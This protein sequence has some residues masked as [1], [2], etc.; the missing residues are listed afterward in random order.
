MSPSTPFMSAEDART[1]GGPLLRLHRAALG[2]DP[3][4]AG[5]AALVAAR[6]KGADLL[7]LA[8]VLAGTAEFAAIHGPGG[9]ETPASSA[10]A[11]QVARQAFGSAD[12]PAAAA[13]GASM[14]GLGRAEA[15][16]GIAEAAPVR[17]RSPLLPGLFPDVPP[18][19]PV[20]YAFWIAAHDTMP[21]DAASRI[22]PLSGPRVSLA[23]R[24]GD[25]EAEAVLRS[26]ASL[27]SQVHQDW[28]LRIACQL[29]SPWPR[30][31]IAAA[32]EADPRIVPIDLP[33]TT[34]AIAALN[35]ALAG[36]TGGIVGLLE[37]GDTLPPTALHEALLAFEPGVMLVFTDEDQADSAGHRTAPRF[38]PDYGPD[39]MQAANVIGQLALYRAELMRPLV[40]LDPDAAP[41]AAYDFACRAACLAGPARIR[42][43]PAVLCHRAAP[44]P[45]DPPAAPPPAPPDPPP[46]VT[47]IL[48]TRDR[49][50]L[51]AASAWGVL[52]GTAYPAL[53][54][55]VVD[56][57]SA[58]PAALAL[59]AEIDADP[60]A[61]VLP[62]PGAFNFPAMNNA[63]AHRARG[64]VLLLL[65]NDV[66]L[67]DPGWLGAMVAHAVRPD[68]GAVGARLLYRDGSL[69]H[70]GMA[71]G[72]AGRATHLLRGAPRDAPGYLGQLAATRDLSAVTAACLAMRADV[73]AQV[74]G[75]DER[76]PVAWNDVDLC[77]R[78]RAAG[79]RVIWTPHAVLLH[80]E[81]ETRGE[82]A[83]DPARQARFLADQALYRETW[84]PAADVDP[85][86]NPNL[87][88][89]DHQLML[90]PPRRPRPWHASAGQVASPRQI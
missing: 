26:A 43:V 71:L 70:G 20:A 57:G 80:L 29:R 34:P 8:R 56:N 9:A 50:D 16:A 53:E 61:E 48:P 66:E 25:S 83:A 85:F 32:A 2:R 73:W 4:A 7:D 65:N 19:Q 64:Q 10:F 89:G 40:G 1:V 63:A 13:L 30:R 72:P 14:E 5:L 59:L 17:A 77:Q 39:A 21:P 46:L 28:E 87:F 55:I 49:A 11:A 3:D 23:M 78:V 22:A 67:V 38:K 33:P 68:V 58:D 37:P 12:D 36:C 62:F 86:L 82:D 42:H 24:S 81:G 88:A 31:A 44:P 52:R 41:H 75:M 84:G 18:D 51:L 79:L 45:P 74:G 69:Q 27:Q 15:L 6:H 54:L 60:R 47:V 90:A 35:H 76:L